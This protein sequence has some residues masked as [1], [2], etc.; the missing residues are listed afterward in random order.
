MGNENY[1]LPIKHVKIAIEEANIKIKEGLSPNQNVLY[2][3]WPKLNYGLLGGF[4]WGSQ[5]VIAGASGS[6]KSFIMNMLRHDFMNPILNGNFRTKFKQIHFCFEMTAADEVIREFST[7]TKKSYRDI[8]SVDSPLSKEVQ[9]RIE[10][11]QTVLMEKEIYF[12]EDSGTTDQV[13]NTIDKFQAQF[14]DHKL[15]I[16]FD[17]SLLLDDRESDEVRLVS[18]FSRAMLS[19]RK[20]INSLNFIIS[21]LNDKMESPERIKNNKLHYP[22]KTD[23]HG[24]K[25]IFR[26]ADIVVVAHAPEQLGIE[27][28]GKHEY[29]TQDL[30]A[31][32]LIK[33]RKGVPYMIRMKNKLGEGTLEQWSDD[34]TTGYG[35]QLTIS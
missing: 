5:V 18:G 30:I 17:H 11:Y 3:R 7:I 6:G 34:F 21:Q 23:I 29:P 8:L 15:I 13:V 35:T 25:A 12:V 10:D 2:T 33:V 1:S 16:S 4:T 22:T 20:K 14:P 32:H 9:L 31:L 19:K 28:Y 27:A 26:D 24:S